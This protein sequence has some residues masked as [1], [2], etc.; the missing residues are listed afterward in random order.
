MEGCSYRSHDNYR[1]LF[2]VFRMSG[3]DLTITFNPQ[4]S[5]REEMLLLSP[6]DWTG[7]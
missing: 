5:L 3:M 1:K 6:L 7:Q 2:S 4:N